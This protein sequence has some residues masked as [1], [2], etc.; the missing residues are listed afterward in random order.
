[1]STSP[2]F[3]I[4]TK[5]SLRIFYYLHTGYC[6]WCF[7]AASFVT[8]D[9]DKRRRVRSPLSLEQNNQYCRNWLDSS[10]FSS[11]AGV[12]TWMGQ[13]RRDDE[14]K[15]PIPNTLSS[16]W[17]REGNGQTKTGNLRERQR[18]A[19]FTNICIEWFSRQTHT[20]RFFDLANGKTVKDGCA[21][22]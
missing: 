15:S 18:D 9:F 5:D 7:F 8:P 4:S 13:P 12:L 14:F 17:A 21:M 11:S 2:W 10:A 22:R 16:S 20:H 3:W 6:N 19:I 1:M